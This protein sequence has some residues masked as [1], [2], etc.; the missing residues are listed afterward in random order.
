MSTATNGQY[1][2]W[3]RKQ[4]AELDRAMR[5]ARRTM[6]VWGVLATGLLVALILRWVT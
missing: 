3:K 2:D 1:P 4:M 5:K 6:I